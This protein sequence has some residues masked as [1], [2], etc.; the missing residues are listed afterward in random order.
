MRFRLMR[1]SG[2]LFETGLLFLLIAACGG[3][4]VR[5]LPDCAVRWNHP[6]NRV[7]QQHVAGQ[8]YDG[9][10]VYTWEG[11][12]DTRGCGVIFGLDGSE[13]WAIYAQTLDQLD[14]APG[15][16]DPVTGNRWGFDSPEGDIPE[17]SNV[18]LGADGMLTSP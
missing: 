10:A 16:W 14:T 5:S 9:V 12:A 18:Q 6:Q 2:A 13:A 15:D 7:N 8:K 1:R 3:D 4:E 17:G 11:K